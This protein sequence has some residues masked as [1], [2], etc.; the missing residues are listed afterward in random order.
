MPVRYRDGQTLSSPFF[1]K[2][3][4]IDFLLSLLKSCQNLAIIR[5]SLYLCI[6]VLLM[7]VNSPWSLSAEWWYDFSGIIIALV[8]YSVM[9]LNLGNS[10]DIY[11]T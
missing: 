11:T 10:I 7:A 4:S 8:L 2:A 5:N 1:C 6:Q 3:A 9:S